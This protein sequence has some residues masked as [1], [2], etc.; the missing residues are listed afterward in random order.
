MIFPILV[1]MINEGN[2]MF[3]QLL[4]VA[5]KLSLLK[6]FFGKKVEEL[7]FKKIFFC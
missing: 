1:T 3:M 7:I 2:K 4:R 5:T 6:T